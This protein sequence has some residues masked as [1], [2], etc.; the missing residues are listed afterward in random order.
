MIA[1]KLY[2][3][4]I[5]YALGQFGW[6][7]A[8]YGVGNL[9]VYFY[10]P[11]AESGSDTRMFPVFIG[12]AAVIGVAGGASRLFDAV[13]DPLIAGWSDRS[14]S[15]LGRRRMF[16]LIGSVPFALGFIVFIA[17]ADGIERGNF[18]AAI[19]FGARTFMQKLGQS[20]SVFIFPII[21][22]LNFGLSSRTDRTANSTEAIGAAGAENLGSA[23]AEGFAG[24]PAGAT[25]RF[26]R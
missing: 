17:D 9:L 13:T 21:I 10:N 6:S 18:K 23:G 1:G 2:G 14:Q 4:K 16:L 12:A 24:A 26:P 15:K 22:S 3:K 20:L 25:R 7:L 19:F 11:P 8:S 5:V